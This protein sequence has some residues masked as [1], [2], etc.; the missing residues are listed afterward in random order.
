[1]AQQP[2]SMDGYAESC[3]RMLKRMAEIRESQ[4]KNES[5]AEAQYE[6]KMV[7]QLEEYQEE[8]LTP[9][10][11]ILRMALDASEQVRIMRQ[12]LQML[13]DI[14][15]THTNDE[16]S[17]P[18]GTM[19]ELL[20]KHLDRLLMPVS[21]FMQWYME[22]S[23]KLDEIEQKLEVARELVVSVPPLNYVGRII[24]SYTDATEQEVIANY[25]G[26]SWRRIENFLRGVRENDVDNIPG[27]KFGEDYV[28]LRESNI[29]IHAHSETI[30]N[31]EQTKVQEWSAKEKSGSSTQLVNTPQEDEGNVES[32]GV[33]NT[34]LEYQVGALEYKV[35]GENDITLPHDNLPPYL[36]VYIWECTE[37]TEDERLVTCEPKDK[38][39]VVTFL[40][41]DGT[42][43]NTQY[44]KSDKSSVGNAPT[45]SRTGF[46]FIGWKCPDGSV[47]SKK[48]NNQI[49]QPV[50]ISD[51]VVTNSFYVAQWSP[52]KFTVTFKGNGG[53]PDT[54]SRQ[55]DYGE[56][57][58]HF[59]TL[60][61]MAP[62]AT[63]LKGWYTTSDTS[64]SPISETKTV[65]ED[66]TYYAQWNMGTTT[67]YTVKFFNG[68]SEYTEWEKTNVVS[69]S[70]IGTLPT[71][72][73]PGYS[74]NGWYTRNEGG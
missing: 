58:G 10:D 45:V 48:S 38:S 43:D 39:W 6:S 23:K 14:F 12:G 5:A 52:Q 57:I 4:S 55:Y 21:E 68:S 74:F 63:S 49:G 7:S 19:K 2:R 33:K 54:M 3:A 27:K 24:V 72:T 26:K 29:P 41:N 28:A 20:E 65:T 71:P 13:L 53:D 16:L 18:D 37:I 67:T 60:D 66:A 64:G 42:P 46:D 36:K 31:V 56:K 40:G 22:K 70:R 61:A 59:P 25:G 50:F 8:H 62:G 73:T 17:T 32:I 47:K 34:E 69:G 30:D 51:E 15:S 11:Y 1:M 44:T 35:K 9:H